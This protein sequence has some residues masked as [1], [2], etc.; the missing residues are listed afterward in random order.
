MCIAFNFYNKAK[1]LNYSICNLVNAVRNSLLPEMILKYEEITNN[2]ETRI[3]EQQKRFLFAVIQSQVAQPA[4]FEIQQCLCFKL[5][6]QKLESK[7]YHSL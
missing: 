6:G 4:L 7:N 1:A 5:A 2:R 3:L